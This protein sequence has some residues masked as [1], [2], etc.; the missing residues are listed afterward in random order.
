MSVELDIQKVYIAYFNRPADSA[1]LEYWS[2]A[3][4]AGRATIEDL[5]SAFASTDEYAALYAGSTNEAIVTK[6]YQNLF[7]REPEAA[8]LQYWVT[9]MNEGRVSVGNV[10][11]SALMGAAGNDL[12]TIQNKAAAAQSFTDYLEA[13]NGD[14]T[15]SGSALTEAREWLDGVGADPGSLAL[16]K[17]TLNDQF[18]D[19][20]GP[21]A[22]G[23]VFSFHLGGYVYE[24]DYLADPL[25]QF[26]FGQDKI[27]LL[28]Y[29]PTAVFY[30]EGDTSNVI[31]SADPY[32][33]ILDVVHETKKVARDTGF[34]Q[35]NDLKAGEALLVQ[36]DWKGVKMTILHLDLDELNEEETV[37][38]GYDPGEAVFVW[39]HDR[40]I[41]LTG[42][43]GLPDLINGSTVEGL[44]LGS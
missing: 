21:S 41:N 14:R 13:N 33:H 31:D 22:P 40:Y 25:P 27:E 5:T 10:A 36:Y 28:G 35:D 17:E 19:L 2:E 26:R 44:F 11:Y 15:Y 43:V 6:V 42:I 4:V 23:E 1:G 38:A 7:G 18:A 3:I 9:E 39:G 30:H 37:D 34:V 29:A 24:D 8:G 16:A 12:S 20:V 32:L